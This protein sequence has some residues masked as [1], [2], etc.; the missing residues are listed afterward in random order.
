M[1]VLDTG[2]ADILVARVTSQARQDQFDVPTDDWR[3]AG[4]LLPSIIRVHKLATLE[5]S[6]IVRTL[7]SLQKSDRD[8]VKKALGK[9][10]KD[11]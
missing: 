9:I 5:K 1:I 2:D 7:G 6:L 4:L 8:D 10:S 11:W 3:G